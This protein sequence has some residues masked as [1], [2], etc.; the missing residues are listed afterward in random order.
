MQCCCAEGLRILII[1]K[2]S[3]D[4]TLLMACLHIAALKMMVLNMVR[5]YTLNTAGPLLPGLLMTEVS[6]T[7]ALHFLSRKFTH[8]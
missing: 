6:A 3:E 2:F 5:L 4:L 7:G 8:R 1:Y